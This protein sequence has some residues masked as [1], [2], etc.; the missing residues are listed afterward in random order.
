MVD[1]VNR[2]TKRTELPAQRLLHW[3]GL[4]KFHDWRK[5]YGKVNE[6][7][8]LIP[9]DEWLEDWEKKAI[10][11]FHDR[12]PLEGYRR[13]CFLMLDKNFV[14]VSPCSGLGGG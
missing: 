4:G 6:H 5:R 8:A 3:L 14:A 12:N 9:R 2:W 11:D 1:Y 7:N 13:L 10:L